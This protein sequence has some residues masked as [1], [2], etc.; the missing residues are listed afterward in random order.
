MGSSSPPDA[1]DPLA[2]NYGEVPLPE[3]QSKEEAVVEPYTEADAL[4]EGM[5]GRERAG[6]GG[7]GRR[8]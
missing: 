3:L 5:K 8:R 2:G 6:E 4:A 1:E 7:G